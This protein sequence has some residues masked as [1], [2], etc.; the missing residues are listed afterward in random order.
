M[1]GIEMN[2]SLSYLGRKDNKIAAQTHITRR[3]SASK[4][5]SKMS[6]CFKEEEKKKEKFPDSKNVK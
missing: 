3:S 4:L 1:L 6:T 2:S 5:K